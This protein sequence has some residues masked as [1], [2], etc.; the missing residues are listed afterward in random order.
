MHILLGP[1]TWHCWNGT[2]YVF[3]WI[4]ECSFFWESRGECGGSRVKCRGSREECRGSIKWQIF[5]RASKKHSLRI[6]STI[7]MSEPHVTQTKPLN[8]YGINMRGVY[9]I[10]RQINLSRFAP[11]CRVCSLFSIANGHFRNTSIQKL[12]KNTFA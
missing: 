6:L 5:F 10:R 7:F 2:V 12:F 4:I 8:P 1:M 3:N 11:F 9:V